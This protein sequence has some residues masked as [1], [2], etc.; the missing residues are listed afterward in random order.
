MRRKGSTF[1]Q[2]RKR[3]PKDVIDKA[4]GVTLAI[5]VGDEVLHI[6]VGDKATEITG[7]LRTR[8]PREAKERQT[9]ALAYLDSAWQSLREGPK[10]LTHKQIAALAG[11]AYNAL[12]AT[13]EDDPGS[14][15]TWKQII[16]LHAK[17]LSG[18][19]DAREKWFGPTVDQT[20]AKH[21]LIIDNDSR[22]ALIDA[23][24]V[25][26]SLA[27]VR[28]AQNAEGDYG[29]DTIAPR[30]PPLELPK[31]TKTTKPL[32]NGSQ[33]II[34]LAEGWWREAKAA[35]RTVSTYDAYSRAARLLSEFVG[36]DD[37][38]A[39]TQDDI[40]AFK[41]HRLSQGVGLKTITGGD[42][43]GIRQ[44]YAWGMANRKVS[45][46]PADG[47]KVA[48]VKKKRV[49]NPEFS[50]EEA[51]ALLAHALHHK[52]TGKASEHLSNAKR[53]VPWLCAYTGARVGEMVQLRKQD[54]R[55]EAGIWIIKITPEAGTVKDAEFRE[56]P[57]HPHLI[58][59]GFPEFIS[60]ATDGYLFMKVFGDTE[61]AQRAAWRTTKNRVTDFAR[62]VVTDP[63]VQPN[64][65]W[66]HKFRTVA[67]EAGI[68]RD[69][70]F[71]ITGH[72]SKDEGDKYGTVTNKA[73][74]A[75]LAKYPRY[76]VKPLENP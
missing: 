62:E 22:T 60:K 46:N 32:P 74:A 2:F 52:R 54:L 1:I 72:D 44:L 42:L 57:L 18:D 65:G 20:L 71:S 11:E 55:A 49:R 67:R 75:A 59:Q 21:R 31:E 64:H 63:E 25:S 34:G 36:H 45:H 58:E 12:V 13:F 68:S 38:R 7:S 39:V 23:V 56:V 37:A 33:T 69:I 26:L 8:D 73:K 76:E 4:G 15:E 3:I 61:E 66:R 16:Q 24:G 30:Y 19:H 5:P 35:G 17:A 6:V 43:P 47:V 28:L 70:S 29:P 53:W 27:S 48:K 51:G 10:R 9:V 14:S 40:I 41:D 50:D